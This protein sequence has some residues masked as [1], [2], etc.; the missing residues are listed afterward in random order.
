MGI[1][2]FI[3]AFFIYTHFFKE[4]NYGVKQGLNVQYFVF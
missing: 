1:L 4:E 2:F 3:S